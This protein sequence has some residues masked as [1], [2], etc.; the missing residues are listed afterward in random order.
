MEASQGGDSYDSII[1]GCGM[2]GLAAGIRL[3]MYGQRVVILEKHNA[4]GGLNSFYFLGGRKFDVGLHAVTNF[5]EP[6]GRGTPLGTLIRQLRLPRDAFQL[7]PQAGSRIA[8]PGAD[9]RFNNDFSLLESE[10][11]RAFPAEIDAF[12]KL[13]QV[14]LEHDALN[15]EAKPLSAREVVSSHISDPVLA[16]MLFCP[17]MYYGSARE[18]DMDFDQF[19]TLWKAIF[20]EG[21]A[22]P[23]EGVRVVIRALLD[24]YRSLGGLRRM[25]CGVRRILLEGDK[26]TG[27]ELENGEV[28]QASH[29]LSTAGWVETKV[30]CGS[31]RSDPQIKANI[32]RLSFAETISVLDAEPRQLGLDETI[33][34]FNDSERFHYEQATE[35]FDLRSGVI[36]IPNNYCYADG[37]SLPEGILRITGI[38]SHALWTGFDEETY[39]AEKAAWFPRIVES[40]LRFVPG[41][42]AGEIQR[43]TVFQDMFTPRTVEKFTS[44]FGGA[45]YGA[46]NKSKSGRT[47][48]E[49]LYLAGTDQGFLGIVGAM[50]SGI[51][52]ANK[53]ILMAKQ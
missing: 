28:L 26:A 11:A 44:H 45:V 50:L 18:H 12:R 37:E 10:V 38:A 3:A 52:M 35:P 13:R 46:P 29:I 32:G 21:F 5:V 17:L 40:A 20:E 34:F 42:E 7:C 47:E 19:V 49:N 2:A 4:P 23:L 8:F 39:T 24:K 33:V 43:R 51:S 22:R 27:V 31:E 53:H 16:D 1:I 9:L 41:A 15:L 14:V 25:K 30:L 48:V 6:Q 36:C